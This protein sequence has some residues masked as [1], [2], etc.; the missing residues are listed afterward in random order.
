[1]VRFL[2]WEDPLERD[3]ATHSSTLAWRIPWMRGAWRTTVHRVAKSQTWL[4]WLSMN[5]QVFTPCGTSLPAFIAFSALQRAWIFSLHTTSL[6][7]SQLNLFSELGL[8]LKAR[9]EVII[10]LQAWYYKP[11]LRSASTMNWQ[12]SAEGGGRRENCS[13]NKVPSNVSTNYSSQK[14]NPRQCFSW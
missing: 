2:G 10:K 12:P 1:M 8:S 11:L 4:K 7:D 6:L 9:Q 3:T 14:L 5:A 13:K